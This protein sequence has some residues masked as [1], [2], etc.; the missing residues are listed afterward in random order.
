MAGKQH[1]LEAR[2]LET[3]GIDT[4]QSSGLA[5]RACMFLLT[6][7][8]PYFRCSAWSRS[9]LVLMHVTPYEAKPFILGNPKPSPLLFCPFL[10][11]RSTSAFV[12]SCIWGHSAK[13]FQS[14]FI[15]G[16]QAESGS[17][18]QAVGFEPKQKKDFNE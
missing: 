12:S 15:T 17:L 3:D 10:S 1:G 14:I 7:E 2:Y 9:A 16:I 8:D 5:W 11:A 18:D 6:P 13:V 4:D